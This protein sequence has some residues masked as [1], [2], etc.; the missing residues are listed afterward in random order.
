MCSR[1]GLLAVVL[2]VTV[3]VTACATVKVQKVPTP[4]QYIRWTDDPKDEQLFIEIV[5]EFDRHIRQKGWGIPVFE[6][7]GELT[8]YREDG[9]KWGMGAYGCLKKAG[10]L[11][12]NRGNGLVDLAV[13]KAGLVD[14]AI[15]N[16][17]LMR[18]K[19]TDTMKKHCK[20][21]WLYNYSRDRYG[22]GFFA[23]K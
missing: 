20:G 13:I 18:D 2:F 4:T 16:T 9:L 15:P 3:M 14:Y 7:V 5:K 22:F 21:L 19:W 6:A 12:A 1:T 10:V 17:A 23:W 11:T 8:A